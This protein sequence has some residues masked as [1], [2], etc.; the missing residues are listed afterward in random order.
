LRLCANHQIKVES[1]RNNT[2]EIP[3]QAI[4]L[5]PEFFYIRLDTESAVEVLAK[6]FKQQGLTV[7]KD[8]KN[9]TL[10]VR[11]EQAA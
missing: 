8:L 5:E 11:R 10:S 9:K 7:K 3:T 6:S 4:V 2:R 1:N